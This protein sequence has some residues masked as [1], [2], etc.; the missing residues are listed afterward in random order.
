MTP[1]AHSKIGIA[2]CVAGVG[3]FLVYLTAL[4]HYQLVTGSY[5]ETPWASPGLNVLVMA[6]L[7]FVPIPVHVIAL[8][9]GIVSLFFPKREKLFPILAIALN[10]VFAIF[11]LFP[12]VYVGWLGLHSGVK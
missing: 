12:W 4:L 2:A 3:M 8:V 1:K 11:S 5:P 7:L 10:A 9:M 6:V